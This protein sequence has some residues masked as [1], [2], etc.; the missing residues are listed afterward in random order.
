MGSQKSCE[1]KLTRWMKENSEYSF[2]DIL[3]AVDIYLE[4]LNGDYRFLQRADYFVF[5][6]ENNREES[7]RL[8]AYIDEIGITQSGDWTTTLK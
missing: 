3:K 4:S 7:S 1:M 5:K 8:S 2:D 6:Q